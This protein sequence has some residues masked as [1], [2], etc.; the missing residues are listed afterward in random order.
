MYINLII[1][2]DVDRGLAIDKDI[3]IDKDRNTSM[4][5]IKTS[6]HLQTYFLGFQKSSISDLMEYD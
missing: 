6:R 1:V 5:T 3:D 2:M 4:T